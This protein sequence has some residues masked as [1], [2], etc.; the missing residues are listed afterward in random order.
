MQSQNCNDI[1]VMIKLRWSY[2]SPPKN[3]ISIFSVS[4]DKDLLSYRFNADKNHAAQSKQLKIFKMIENKSKY[5]VRLLSFVFVVVVPS[6]ALGGKENTVGTPGIVLLDEFTFNKT[7]NKFP[8][9]FVQIS[10]GSTV[11]TTVDK[12][13]EFSLLNLEFLGHNSDIL[14]AEVRL[15]WGTP[16]TKRLA[17]RFQ[18][19]DNLALPEFIL[20]SVDKVKSKPGRYLYA[21][22]TRYGGEVSVK[23]MVY[24][25]KGKIILGLT[26]TSSQSF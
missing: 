24:F 5:L 6:Q 20:F 14:A 26:Y 18:I 11:K 12:K 15:Q 3:L 9:V 13:T 22:E 10:D 7:V 17:T 2:L 23:Q 4:K 1:T 16:E 19:T 25:L 8:F 21:N